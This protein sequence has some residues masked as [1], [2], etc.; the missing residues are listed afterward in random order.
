M[1]QAARRPLPASEPSL[2]AALPTPPK[3][4]S[5]VVREGDP[6]ASAA[7]SV[8]GDSMQRPNQGRKTREAAQVPRP[9]LQGRG[10]LPGFH[11]R[12]PEPLPRH[13]PG[14]LAG[15]GA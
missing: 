14:L 15:R 4:A 12:T 13:P 3:A 9:G 7:S 1:L 2:A 6:A 10:D 11:E 8:A 5:S